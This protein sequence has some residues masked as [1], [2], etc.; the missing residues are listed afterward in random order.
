MTTP[1]TIPADLWVGET[2]AILCAGPSLTQEL[3]DSVRQHK[4]IA[5]RR[6]FQL[7]PDADLLV[8]LDGPTGSADDAFWHDVRDFAGQRLC[9]VE[10]E[11]DAL[12]AGLF[13]E[14]VVIDANC[15][16]QIRNN[17]LAAIRIAAKAGAA[18]ILLL[19]FDPER[20]EAVHAHTGFYGLVQ[21]LEQITAELRAAGIAVERLD[22]IK[23]SK[24]Q[25]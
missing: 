16:L 5:V 24:A 1:W 23:R 21:G 9:G 10:C 14:T 20:Y 19:G 15:T 6:A 2:V 25:K 17:G 18:K 13:Y 8:S 3:A 12:Y 7:A 22:A 4:R 11:V